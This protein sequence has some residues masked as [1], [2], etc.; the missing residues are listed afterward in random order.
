[1]E[2][3]VNWDKL[4]NYRKQ[5]Q[6]GGK[7][8]LTDFFS[9]S[10]ALNLWEYYYK[11]PDHQYDLAIYPAIEKLNQPDT[12]P[13]YRCK[14]G[15]DSIPRREKLARKFHTEGQFSYIYR[16]TEDFHP[17]L[18]VFS[19]SDFVQKLEYIT[20]YTNLEFS[21]DATFVSNY[22]A[23][24]FNGPHHDGINGRIAFVFHL[25]RNWKAWHGG[26]FIRLDK[27]YSQIDAV[28][29]PSF[30]KLV[31]FDVYGTEHGSPHLVTE[32]AQ[33]CANRRISFTGWYN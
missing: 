31:V 18:D 11:K 25:S 8:V 17:L 23:G 15:D 1:M 30:N 4:E 20:G 24:H 13:V 28:V 12:Y 29:A 14:P 2:A 32:I 3:Q 5:W 7:A 22:S 26:L 27:D 19:T 33:G 16:R 6:E 21:W 10:A 9:E